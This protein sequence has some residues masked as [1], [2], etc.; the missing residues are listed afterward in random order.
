MSTFISR[1]KA[2]FEDRHRGVG[3][4]KVAVNR[5]D[6]DDLVFHF[7]RLDTWVRNA[8]PDRLA[9][10]D[11]LRAAESERDKYK[12]WYDEALCAANEAGYV[13]TAAEA[14]AAL[15][16]ER[17][18]LAKRLAEI[19]TQ[20]PV[21]YIGISHY[22]DKF[23]V[24]AD[25]DAETLARLKAFPVYA[26]PPVPQSV[27]DIEILQEA[28]FKAD[29]ILHQFHDQW[30]LYAFDCDA[31]DYTNRVLIGTGTESLLLWAQET[32]GYDRGPSYGSGQDEFNPE[33][34]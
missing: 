19:E 9:M 22:G 13:M 8:E 5:K 1:I 18:A 15:D 28:L 7:E 27:P 3:R 14:I 24:S 17:D 16:D 6:L 31:K 12:G 30:S 26:L 2:A 4:E 23:L 32:I 10:V 11:R 33:V 20:V 29:V 21:G 25:C 34:K